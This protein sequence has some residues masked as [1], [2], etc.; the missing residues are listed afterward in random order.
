M[1]DESLYLVAT[2]EFESENLIPALWAKA[3]ALAEGDEKRAK[4]IYIK[5]R[6]EQISNAE[7][8]LSEFGDEP[9]E[10]FVDEV[11]Q[12]II[13]EVIKPLSEYSKDISDDSL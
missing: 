11:S 10:E 8:S 12:N 5:L 7:L 9:I 4:Y 6:V 3:I 13:E 2:N 1:D